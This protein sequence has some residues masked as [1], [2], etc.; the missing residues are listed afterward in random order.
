MYYY[1]YEIKNT[2]NGKIY[3]G[4]HKTKN[5]DDGYMG[6]GVAIRQAIKKYGI[7]AFTKDILEYFETA[8]EMYARE[9]EIVTEE[10]ISRDDVYN[11]RCGG[12]GGFEEIN[13]KG[14]NINHVPRSDEFK[15]NLSER[16]KENNPS[17][18]PGAKERMSKASKKMMS[19]GN[20]PFK[21]PDKQ[22]ELR[23]RPCKDGRSRSQVS[24]DTV[25]KMVESGTHNFLHFDDVSCEHCGKIS[26]YPNYKRWHGKNCKHKVPEVEGH[27]EWN[28]DLLEE[29]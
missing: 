20:H 10:F 19:T 14:L 27:R 17:K 12:Q 26:N 11:M 13:K 1:L 15:R 21:D 5:L 3:V 25:T 23:N 18:K 2:V 29:F 9:R 24:K 16:M 7:A 8:A 22:R 6:S 4:V 28:E